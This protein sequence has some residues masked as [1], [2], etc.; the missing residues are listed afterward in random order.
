MRLWHYELLPYLPELQ[1]KGQ[2][3]E[4]ALIAYGLK[5]HGTPNHLLVNK[6]DEYSIDHFYSYCVAVWGEMR[7]RGFTTTVQS[8]ERVRALGGKVVATNTLF[9]GWHNKEY[10][11]VCM[12]NLYEKY[13]FGRGKS[14]IT[15][16]EWQRLLDG[17]KNITE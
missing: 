10:L 17:Y 11:R 7:K 15:E 8:M 16:A 6:V 4:C 1:L 9:E 12:A 3:R 5:E 2:W 13:N 14:R